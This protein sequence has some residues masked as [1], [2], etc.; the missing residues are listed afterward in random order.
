MGTGPAGRSQSYGRSASACSRGLCAHARHSSHKCLC[1]PAAAAQLAW[2]RFWWLSHEVHTALLLI[3]DKCQLLSDLFCIMWLHC[4]WL[5]CKSMT[6]CRVHKPLPEPR[7]EPRP[8]C[9]AMCRR[10]YEL[11]FATAYMFSGTR[12]R[13]IMVDEITFQ[14]PVDVGDL[15]RLRSLVLHTQAL[16]D[17]MRG[18]ATDIPA[19]ARVVST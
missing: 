12:P 10:A 1:V 17:G 18:V 4:T 11:A 3:R 9:G 19:G 15:L 8:A 16:P 5:H 2:T 7:P 13:F 6:Q 14:R